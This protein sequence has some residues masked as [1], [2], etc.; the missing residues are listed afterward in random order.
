MKKIII[1]GATGNIGAYFTD[2]C[3][4][5]L[6]SGEYEIIATGRKKTDFYNKKEIKYIHVDLCKP[7]TFDH[8]PTDD[9]YAVVNLTG[10]LPAYLKAYDPFAYVETN[11][12]G[13]LRILEY[14]RKSHADRVL[15][16][17]TWADQAGYW[18]KE[19]VLSPDMPRKLLYTGD[20]AFYSITKSMIVDTMEHYKQE[21]GLKNFVF[22]LPNVYLYHP[23]KTYYVDGVSKP[24]G[25]R[26]MIDKASKG[27]TIEMWGNPDAFKDILY[28]KDLCRMM[29]LA[30]FANVDGG[31]YNAGTGIKTT[32]REQIEG[33]VEVFS[34]EGK[35]SQIIEKP[36][37]AGFTSF[38][39]DIENA[40]RD[41]G[42]EPE[43]TYIKYLQDYKCEQE[44]KRFDE[45]WR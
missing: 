21:Y 35:K 6:D 32:L 22:R 7:E 34:P 29:F 14:A 33:M 4:Q 42:Y 45:L 15:Y 31:M 37:G 17:Q 20:H 41:L 44:Q 9:V 18:G 28:I 39:M 16:T 11:I 5:M 38:V 25:Y 19:E 40:R 13:A 12:N 3:S 10:L 2:Y 43:Y 36:E 26:Y 24:I 23:Q 30:L 1:F 27:E 8:L